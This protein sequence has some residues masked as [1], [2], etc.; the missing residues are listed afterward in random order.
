MFDEDE[1]IKD[2]QYHSR[3]Q[4]ADDEQER[5]AIYDLYCSNEKGEK[6]IIE[7]QRVNQEFFKDRSL[8][9]STFPIQK[10]SRRGGWN[11]EL[12]SVYFIGILDFSFDDSDPLKFHHRVKLMEEE[13]KTVF[14]NKLNMVY[15]E[16]PKFTKTLSELTSDYDRWLYLFK[17]LHKLR[18][19]PEELEQG[20][21]K[22]LFDL[23]EIKKLNPMEQE[24]YERS[25]KKYW[26]IYSIE[27]TNLKKGRKEGKAIGIEKGKQIGKE[28]GLKEGEAIGLEK[29]LKE[30]QGIVIRMH[31]SGRSIKEIKDITGLSIERITEI[32]DDHKTAG[33]EGL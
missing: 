13:S 30:S 10:Q 27:Q 24:T 5:R 17:N 9:Y 8:F 3:E 31:E 19:C 4:L 14:Y 20:I 18:D 7:V 32:I 16:I 6:F 2:I 15:L 23:A 12:K 29:G 33:Q 11:Y 1:V 25:L 28:I 26:D 21:F 22:R